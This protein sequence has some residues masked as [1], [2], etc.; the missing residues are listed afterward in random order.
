M[1]SPGAGQH[2]GVLLLSLSDV[3]S[4]NGQHSPAMLLAALLAVVAL[5]VCVAPLLSG[6][7]RRH[8][9][10]LAVIAFCVAGK[11]ASFPINLCAAEGK[12][13]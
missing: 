6:S 2:D 5:A 9:D 13:R 3:Q 4:A 8:R 10:N 1:D 12:Q 7:R 11:A